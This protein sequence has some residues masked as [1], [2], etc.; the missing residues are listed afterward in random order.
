M[1]S[2]TALQTLD[3]R[4]NNI[5]D[6]GARATADGVKSNTALQTLDLYGNRIGDEG[7]KAIADALKSNTVLRTLSLLQS[8]SLCCYSNA[9]VA[10]LPISTSMTQSMTQTSC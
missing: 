5:G 3:L 4:Y 7:A 9:Q 2:K 10:Y 8:P 1:K 6:E